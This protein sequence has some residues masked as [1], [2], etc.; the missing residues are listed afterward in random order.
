MTIL[1]GLKRLIVSFQSYKQSMDLYAK[2]KAEGIIQVNFNLTDEEAMDLYAKL[3]TEGS[4]QANSDLTEEAIHQA[5]GHLYLNCEGMSDDQVDA[6]K[7][8]LEAYTTTIQCLAE[9]AS[10]T[11]IFCIGLFAYI[12]YQVFFAQ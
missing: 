9:A 4:I 11:R 12:G 5:K 10:Y 6:A 2:L 3:K 7:K 8:A 1:S